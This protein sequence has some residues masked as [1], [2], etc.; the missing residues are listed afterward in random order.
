MASYVSP[1]IGQNH[2]LCRCGSQF[3]VASPKELVFKFSGGAVG[4]PCSP[5]SSLGPIC[6]ICHEGDGKEELVAPC[7]CSGTM[8]LVH[9]TCIEKWLSAA[10]KETCEICKYMF[11]T[12]RKPRPYR[13]WLRNPSNPSDLRTLA[14]DLLCFVLLTPMAAVSAYLCIVGARHY[15]LWTMRWEASGLV[16]LA[17]FL[18]SIYCIWCSVTVRYH[19][20]VVS[21]WRESHQQVKLV[22]MRRSPSSLC[23]MQALGAD[24]NNN[25]SRNSATSSVAALNRSTASSTRHVIEMRHYP[26]LNDS[27]ALS[28][29]G[30]VGGAR[31]TTSV[32]VHTIL[33]ASHI[34]ET[35]V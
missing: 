31:F 25:S 2:N 18:I 23:M 3:N 13:E 10:N 32:T 17:V 19:V 35:V 33:H 27:A 34:P 24:A 29:A 9:R 8:A 1:S 15:A 14:G 20:N 30:A 21:D 16:C 11:V 6:R 4:D 7:R 28:P 22:Q 12:C 26:R 5:V